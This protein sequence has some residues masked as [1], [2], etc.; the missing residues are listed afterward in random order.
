MLPIQSRG[1]TRNHLGIERA[2]DLKREDGV[3]G[4]DGT[5]DDRETIGAGQS[6]ERSGRVD[7]GLTNELSAAQTSGSHTYNHTTGALG[8]DLVGEALGL[9]VIHPNRR[10]LDHRLKTVA[11][12]H[13]CSP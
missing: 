4:I 12:D 2:S 9:A 5:L 8:A 11:V 6:R 3:T 10:A 13:L 7:S 1:C